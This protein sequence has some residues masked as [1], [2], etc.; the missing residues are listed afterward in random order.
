MILLKQKFINI[1]GQ[2]PKDLYERLKNRKM[3]VK[4]EDKEIR[5]RTTRKLCKIENEENCNFSKLS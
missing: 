4:E 1:H 2:I 3:R 5:E